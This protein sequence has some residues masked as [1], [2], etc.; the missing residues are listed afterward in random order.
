MSDSPTQVV[1]THPVNVLALCISLFASAIVSCNQLRDIFK[2][3]DDK[4]LK[5]RV[6][7]LEA[8]RKIDR[9]EI[10]KLKQKLVP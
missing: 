1:Q 10:E 3:S 5:Q 4:D 8:G 6:E 9:I 7:Q 2:S